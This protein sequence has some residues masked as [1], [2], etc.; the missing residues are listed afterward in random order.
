VTARSREQGSHAGRPRGDGSPFTFFGLPLRATLASGRL[1]GRSAVRAGHGAALTPEV[2]PVPA[3]QAV[4]DGPPAVDGCSAV[5]AASGLDAPAVLDSAVALEAPPGPEVPPRPEAP[6]S[7]AAPG[8]PGEPAE[9]LSWPPRQASVANGAGYPPAAA[10]RR[11]GSRH[12][13]PPERRPF[14]SGKR[15]LAAVLVLVIGVLAVGFGTGFGS[16]VSAEPTVQAFLLDWQ[17]GSYA[18]A[19]ALTNGAGAA[20]T[21]QL[22]AAYTDLDATNEFFALDHITQHGNTAVATYKATADLAQAGQEWSYVGQFTL[23]SQTGHWV[24]DWTPALI[25]PGLGAGD[26]LAVVTQFAPRAA[27]EDMNGTPLLA[28]SADYRIGVDPAALKNPSATAAGFSHLTG[29]DGQQVLGQIEAA[30]PRAFLSLLT[31]DAADF[32]SLWPK[33]AK[34]PGLSYQKH[35]ARLFDSAAADAVGQVGTEDSSELRNE[36]AAYQPGMTVGLGGLEEGYQNELV[37]TPT[38]SVVVVNAAGRTV[39]TLWSSAGGRAGTPVQTTLNSQVQDDATRALAGQSSSAEIVAVDTR[40][41]A[42]RALAS[43]EAG[44]SKLPAGGALDAK[45][46]PGMAFSIV[47]AAALLS[48]GVSLKQALPCESVADV[49]GETFTYQPASSSSSTLAAD[50]ADGCGTAF[51]NMSRTLTARQLTDAERS[52][53]I[54]ASWHLP[55]QAF[56]GSA[57]AASGEADVAAQATGTGGVL[58]S[59]LGM[60]TVAAEVANGAGHAPTLVSGDQSSTWQPPLSAAGLNELRL[61]MR[62]AVTSGS[63]KAANRSGTPV[64]GQAG[65]VKSGAHSYLSWFVGYRGDLAVTVLETGSTASQ[66]AAALAGTFLKSAG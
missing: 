55:L 17:Q 7:P 39:T 15:R 52:F 66:A 25:N 12:R 54:G 65:V 46:E 23:S 10:P 13:K 19:A 22:A 8:L 2:P 36:G 62:L 60:A 28:K 40:T 3:G 42:I 11:R 43:D 35:T 49:G 21:T 31:L 26:R 4:L 63:A 33:L 16:E 41:G 61:L 47:T 51:A 44:S 29:L 20:V 30:P 18:Q 1:G 59:P 38:T 5:D 45:V 37:G 56:S 53:G 58:M 57:A 32:G 14:L 9:R 64:Y 48:T 50:F 24:I 6:P 27:I 34:V